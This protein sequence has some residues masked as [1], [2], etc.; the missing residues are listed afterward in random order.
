[1]GF[2]K[3]GIHTLA[4]LTKKTPKDIAKIRNLGRKGA[5]EIVDKVYKWGGTLSSK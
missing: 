3:A 2:R 4:D 1:M 5:E